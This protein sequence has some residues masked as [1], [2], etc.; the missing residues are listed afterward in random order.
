MI[1]LKFNS[2][3]VQEIV[4]FLQFLTI[5]L[6]HMCVLLVIYMNIEC[7]KYMCSYIRLYIYS[8]RYKP[9]E[10][11]KTAT[12]LISAITH[13][14]TYNKAHACAAMHI[15]YKIARSVQFPV[16][17]NIEESRGRTIPIL[18]LTIITYVT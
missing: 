2:K 18:H 13:L 15:S 12:T 7:V 9:S 5:C 10:G 6:I 8:S 14:Y 3:Y 1:A 11:I 4:H 17:Q 16:P